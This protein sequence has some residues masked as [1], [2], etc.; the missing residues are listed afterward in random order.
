[1][2]GVAGVGGVLLAVDD[3]PPHPVIMVTVI[4]ITITPKVTR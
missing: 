3:D 2:E 1:M 4:T